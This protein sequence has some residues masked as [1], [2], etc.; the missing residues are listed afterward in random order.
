MKADSKNNELGSF[1]KIKHY[2]SS[3]LLTTLAGFIT[4]PILTRLLTKAD[5][6][7]FSV[8]QG[9]QL[10]Y[11]AILKSGFQFSIRR[12]YPLEYAN[13]S[14]E[15]RSS[16]KATFLAFPILATLVISL[17][18]GGTL[19]ILKVLF[20]I[21]EYWYL[22]V[23]VVGQCGVI[24]S[25]FKSY[26]QASGESLRDSLIDIVNK[27]LYLLLVI[28]MVGWFITSYEGV[29]LAIFITV[30]ILS[31][32]VIWVHREIFQGAFR[33][34][35][36]TLLRESL[37]YSLPLMMVE[38][39]IISISYV[40][41]IIMAWLDV[42]LDKIGIY[43]IGFG[44]AN[45]VF[46]LIWK[47]MHAAI[48]PKVNTIHDQQGRNESVLYLE[49]VANLLVLFFVI[50][51]ASIFL[52]ADYFVAII[53]GEDKA[54]AGEIFFFA[55]LLF[56][57]RIVA[58]LVMYGYELIKKTKMVL[59][60]ELLIAVLNILLNI[61]LIPMYDIYGALIS[62]YVS[63]I[64]GLILKYSFLPKSYKAIRIFHSLWVV[65]VLALAYVSIHKL[66]LMEFLENQ[67]LIMLLSGLVFLILL[68]L[69]K[70]IW[71]GKISKVFS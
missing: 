23:V 63:I 6:G 42:S 20:G 8:I 49:S 27:Y 68:S 15:S 12:Y 32:Y 9:V 50:L 43:S 70:P 35:N 11:E 1:N 40:D 66:V 31:L 60:S 39:S 3:G 2:L 62:S 16:Y 17:L 5:Y 14:T 7:V 57:I 24:L 26:M 10:I 55:T 22:M 67:L 38:L 51:S 28:P 64:I 36:T 71:Q 52:N 21:G 29:Y 19:L 46:I 37:A 56:F 33:G 30:S 18:V 61:I 44:L 59:Y 4:F 48:L 25:F 54:E 65:V 47:V 41:R 58:N 69:T 13:G 45:V 34:P 53:C